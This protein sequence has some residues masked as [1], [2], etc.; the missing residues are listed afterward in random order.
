MANFLCW[1]VRGLKVIP[2]RMR[3]GGSRW[4]ISPLQCL[5]LAQAAYTAGRRRPPTR[6]RSA[7]RRSRPC[8]GPLAAKPRS[9]QAAARCVARHRAC[10]SST[11]FR[12]RPPNIATKHANLRIFATKRTAKTGIGNDI[13]Y[14]LASKSL[15]L[16]PALSPASPTADADE[17][18]MRKRR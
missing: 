18:T 5:A 7:S 16:P 4:P 10:S 17:C 6:W 15:L 12:V 13:I 9:W 2:A 3:R 1:C 8:R 11:R 14:L